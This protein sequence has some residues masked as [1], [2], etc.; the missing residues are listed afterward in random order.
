MGCMMNTMLGDLLG[1]GERRIGVLGGSF[2]PIHMGHLILAE[3]ALEVFA[4]EQVFFMPCASQPLKPGAAHAD[5][6]ARKQMILSAI[7]GHPQFELLD[8]ELER[9]GVSYT[10]DSLEEIRGR[11]PDRTIYFLIGADK[12]RELVQWKDIGRVVALCRFGV[13]PRPGEP[14]S[15]PAGLPAAIDVAFAPYGRQIE[16]SSSELRH[17]VAEGQSIRYLVPGGV[18]MIIAERHLYGA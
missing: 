12:L 9:G 14:L 16:I 3:A 10:V 15:V 8:I 7:E 1:S 11:F 17:R 2:D 4:L 5:E 18:E 6:A 13:F